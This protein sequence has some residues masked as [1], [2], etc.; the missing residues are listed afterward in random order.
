[1]TIVHVIVGLVAA[2]VAI[3]AWL[4]FNDR[5]ARRAAREEAAMFAA[6]EAQFNTFGADQV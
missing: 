4:A 2:N 5:H 3:V 1:M 6:F